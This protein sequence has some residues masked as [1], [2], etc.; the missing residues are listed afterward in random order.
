MAKKGFTKADLS[1]ATGIRYASIFDWYSGRSYP[2]R[3][4]ME[5]VANALGVSEDN[6]RKNPN[7]RIPVLGRI[8]AGVP[9]EAIEEILD[10]EEISED[11]LKGDK[12]YFALKISGDSMYPEYL[13]GDVVIF[14]KN[15]DC[16]NGNKCAVLVNGNDAT[17]KKVTK[18]D[19][20][21]ILQPLN[22]KYDAIQ[23]TNEEIIS[24]P[25]RIIG[26][27]KEIRRK[28]D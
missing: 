26:I 4:N 6:L 11:M 20:G 15:N 23:F 21:I 19:N 28:V 2:N 22:P 14:E 5:K 13:D 9:I 18:N 24:I 17:F 1:N 7:N 8:P 25:V 12:E 16:E 10:Y 27:A 3:S